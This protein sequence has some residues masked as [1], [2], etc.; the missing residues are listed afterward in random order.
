[1][2]QTAPPTDRTRNSATRPDLVPPDERF[3][4]RYSPHAEFP[5]SGAGSLAIHI[6]VFGLLGLL[7]WLGAVLFSHSSRSLPV[8]AV[9]LDLG[10]GGG[11]PRGQR[12]WSQQRPGARR[13]RQ[14]TP[15]RLHG[16]SAHGGHQ[17]SQDSGRDTGS[18]GEAAV[19][20]GRDPLHPKDGKRFRQNLQPFERRDREN[21]FARPQRPRLRERRQGYR[22]R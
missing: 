7:A 11:N 16:E 1:M 22:R 12:R 14:P 19:Q 2:A 18:A 10:G 17:A 5:L 3:W 4:Q 6:L 20:F 21:P 8:E 13:G 9:R 15:G